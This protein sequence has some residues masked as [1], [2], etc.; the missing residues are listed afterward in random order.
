VSSSFTTC[1]C[2]VLTWKFWSLPQLGHVNA[3][4]ELLSRHPHDRAL[5]P[6]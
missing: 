5:R 2:S 1:I 6:V 4:P 3:T